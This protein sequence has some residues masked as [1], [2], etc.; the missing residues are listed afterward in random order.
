MTD[1][2]CYMDDEGPEN[3]TDMIGYRDAEHAVCDFA[4]GW[5]DDYFIAGGGE[6]IAVV[7]YEAGNVQRFKVRAEQHTSYYADEVNHD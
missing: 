5:D 6:P 2:K 1:F 7:I 4:Q 3:A